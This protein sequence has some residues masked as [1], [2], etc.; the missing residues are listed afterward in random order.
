MDAPETI[1][2]PLVPEIQKNFI[3]AAIKRSEPPICDPER[4]GATDARRKKRRRGRNGRAGS[5]D[6]DHRTPADEPDRGTRI[7]IRA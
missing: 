1:P 6:A 4:E 2:I 3:P 5:H 7:N